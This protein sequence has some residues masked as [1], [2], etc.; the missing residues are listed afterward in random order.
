MRKLTG[1]KI[2]LATHN[3]GK[4]SEIKVL[5]DPFGIECVSVR[6]LGLEEP[7]ET[8]TSFV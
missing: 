3:K 7:E 8:E 1:S 6:D 5:L 4:L 2:V